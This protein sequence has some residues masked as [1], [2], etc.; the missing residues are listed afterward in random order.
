MR[1]EGWTNSNPKEAGW[2]GV[3]VYWRT[4]MDETFPDAIFWDG[5]G[6]L[7]LPSSNPP[8]VFMRSEPSF[9]T[10]EEAIEWAE[11]NYVEN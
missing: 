7:I 3:V 6:W 4:E 11:D 5:N 9:D 1:I 10:E 8:I 2:Y